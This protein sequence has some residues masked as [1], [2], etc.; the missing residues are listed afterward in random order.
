MFQVP[1]DILTNVPNNFIVFNPSASHQV[2]SWR[3]SIK[4]V[5]ECS[6]MSTSTFLS[7]SQ[8]TVQARNE[9]GQ[10]MNEIYWSLSINYYCFS[11]TTSLDSS[12]IAYSH[13]TMW[14]TLMLW[15]ILWS[16]FLLSHYVTNQNHYQHYNHFH[17]FVVI[18]Y[19]ILK[20]NISIHHIKIMLKGQKI[21][22]NL[23]Q[24]IA[25]YCNC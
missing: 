24:L 20:M 14:L 10:I 6:P 4:Y 3:F 9:W 16:F 21:E 22:Q 7:V 2:W 5:A 23:S 1:S 17:C 19:D 12:P 11:I 15:L 25:D 13:C 8:Y 18:I